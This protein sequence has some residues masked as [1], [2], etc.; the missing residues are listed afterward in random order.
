[1]KI[2]ALETAT[3][4]CSVALYIDGA[5]TEQFELAP[6]MH[7][8]LVLP[9]CEAVL[10][11]GGLALGAL[12]A[13][14]FGCGP[15]S[16]TGLRIAAGVIQ[17]LALGADLPV[18]PVSTLAALAQQ[19]FIKQEVQCAFAALD[20][21]MGEVYWGV[22]QCDQNDLAELVGEE[23]VIT[24]EQVICPANRQGAGVGH[25]WRSYQAEL[26]QRLAGQ[27]VVINDEYYPRAAEVSIL[28]VKPV[29]AGQLVPAEQALPVYLRNQVA[30]K[31][32]IAV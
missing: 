21:R 20:A 26:K 17:G 16:F 14:A 27:V 12:D 19:V 31:P 2:L 6:R 8:T 11:E 30:R 3:E 29:M 10:A 4:A 23:A 1:M 24:A 22:Y 15:G 32:V 13:L 9:M 28:A 25:G 5:I 18:A 7:A